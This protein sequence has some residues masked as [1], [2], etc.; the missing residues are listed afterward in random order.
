LDAATSANNAVPPPDR[1]GPYKLLQL[2]GSGGFGEVW[3]A[4]RREPMVQRVALKII[5]AGMDDASF[6]ARF[7]QER[8]ALAVI[9]HPH[10]ARV[11]DGGITESGRPFFVMEYV[12]GEPIT[13][14]ADRHR[15]DLAARLDLFADVCDAIQHAHHKGII[16]RDIKPANVM[17]AMFEGKP[18]VKVID[19][20]IAKSTKAAEVPATMHTTQAV[21]I[22]TPEYMSPEQAG[23]GAID[24][25]IRSDVY[26]L[27]ILLY[28]LLSG[29]LPLR[30]DPKQ[31]AQRGYAYVQSVIHDFEP[32]APSKVL[33]T[34]PDAHLDVLA[35]A[36]SS[37]RSRLLES[38]RSE[39]EW[40]PLKAIRKDRSRRYTSAESLA[41]DVRRYLSG[42]PLEAAPESRM[43]LIR[44]FVGRH[45]LQVVAATV[46]VLTLMI[47]VILTG[48]ALTYSRAKAEELRTLSE[49]QRD[50]LSQIDAR[51]AGIRL[52]EDIAARFSQAQTSA[53]S[54]GN[55]DDSARSSE[56]AGM[57]DEVSMADV[58]NEFLVRTILAPAE[59]TIAARFDDPKQSVVAASL[60]QV[61]AD[62]YQSRGFYERAAA[63]QRFALEVRRAELGASD[64]DLLHSI[65]SQA[66]LDMQLSRLDEAEAG[67]HEVLEKRES[68]LGISHPDTIESMSAL[69]VLYRRQDNL[70]LAKRFTGEALERSRV[71]FGDTDRRTRTMM[72]RMGAYLQYS[73]DSAAAE[74]WFRKSLEG[75]GNSEDSVKV[76]SIVTLINLGIALKSQK[77]FSEAEVELFSAYGLCK[78]I[79]GESHPNSLNTIH[80]IGDLRQRQRNLDDA[81]R[82]FRR[83]IESA[84]S[85][86]LDSDRSLYAMRF[87]W[88]LGGICELRGDFEAAE[89]AYRTA[90]DGHR[91]SLPPAHRERM[92]SLY[93]L[94]YAL[95]RLN[96][97]DEAE[98][99]FL[100]LLDVNRAAS[101]VGV[102]T[103]DSLEQLADIRAA[104]GEF[105][106]AER[107]LLESL[108]ASDALHGR[109]REESVR[110][111]MKIVRLLEQWAASTSD[112]VVA[113]R[114]RQSRSKLQ[115]RIE[116]DLSSEMK[117]S[118][119]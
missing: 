23:I 116:G 65:H 55:S 90:V 86:R 48:L 49:F 91:V 38:L 110:L 66:L 82:W 26:S 84:S 92:K 43:Y 27:G 5:K 103:M 95:K 96:R 34:V 89:R 16:H 111:V 21:F 114:W 50:M 104:R 22:G 70:E 42:Q 60:K 1:V 32:V 85:N 94:G 14:F 87:H 24:I 81:E 62:Q 39:L 99:C 69:G 3:L 63:M 64:P 40:I 30:F 67:L 7:E 25:D 12:Q 59:E 6:I 58:A 109:S 52:K 9:D 47:G 61:L 97:L 118:T 88:R 101:R 119:E 77:R 11:L 100:E 108:A 79:F 106:E 78:E 37:S 80:E 113:E 44:K 71:A 75:I 74:Q 36:R 35:G 105:V 17:V 28:E 115:K 57:L 98:S 93:S 117:P 73:G 31:R 41:R 53:E 10:V 56:F 68:I 83:G 51:S 29:V 102:E 107:L 19:F 15:L 8:Q 72:G 76:D 112:Q 54:V 20:G 33:T 18:N 13:L 45:K 46:A 2:I 4:E